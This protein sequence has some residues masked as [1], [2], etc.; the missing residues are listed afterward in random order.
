[1]MANLLKER[2]PL[3]IT[4][5][6]VTASLISL[7]ILSISINLQRKLRGLD[8]SQQILELVHKFTVECVKPSVCQPSTA[9]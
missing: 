7:K 8:V 1:M 5:Q 6:F 4:T 3:N 2:R 9:T